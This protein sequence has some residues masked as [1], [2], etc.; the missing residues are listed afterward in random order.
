VKVLVDTSVWADYFNG[1]ATPRTDYL[2]EILG[3]APVVVGDLIVFEV[4]RGIA[5]D[6]DWDAARRALAKFQSYLLTDGDIIQQSSVHLR[7]LR[8]K[9]APIPNPVDCFIATFCIR[10]NIALLHSDP[11]FEPF[12][13]YL[14]LKLPDPGTLPVPL[15]S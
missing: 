8:T 2:H 12:E 6:A 7:I 10:W 4:L 5:S 14:G 3:W 1:V 15:S 9:G 13:R 11:A